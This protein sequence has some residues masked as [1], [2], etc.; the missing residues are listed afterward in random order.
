MTST[1]IY[2]AQPHERILYFQIISYDGNDEDNPFDIGIRMIFIHAE[3]VVSALMYGAIN[4]D[5]SM[6]V[7]DATMHIAG[8]SDMQSEEGTNALV[9]EASRLLCEHVAAYSDGLARDWLSFNTLLVNPI[10]YPGK[11]TLDEPGILN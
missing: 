7:K 10:Q 3:S 4:Q 2:Q 9:T 8:M 11:Q 5:G 6:H 1:T